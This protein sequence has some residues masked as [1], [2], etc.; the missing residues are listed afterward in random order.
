MV[1]DEC[2]CPSPYDAVVEDPVGDATFGV[3]FPKRNRQTDK[4]GAAKATVPVA[5]DAREI[6]PPTDHQGAG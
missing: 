3:L 5:G 2:E 4:D 6:R 1:G